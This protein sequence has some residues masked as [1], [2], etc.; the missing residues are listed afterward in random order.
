MR[1]KRYPEGIPIRWAE[2]VDTIQMLKDGTLQI[3]NCSNATKIL[4]NGVDHQALTLF[5]EIAF[6]IQKSGAFPPVISYIQ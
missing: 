5:S 1:T 2:N 3:K 6:E 4:S